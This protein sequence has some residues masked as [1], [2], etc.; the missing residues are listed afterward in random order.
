M[1]KVGTESKAYRIH[2]HV[3]LL[4]LL[5]KQTSLKLSIFLPFLTLDHQPDIGP[6]AQVRKY[7][8]CKL[9]L[10]SYPSVETYF[11]GTQ[12]TVHTE[13]VLT[14][15]LLLFEYP[16]HMFWLKRINKIYYKFLSGGLF[17]HTEGNATI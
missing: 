2:K 13:T 11:T 10:F 14:E 1:G 3:Q 6:L 16:Q 4:R 5:P 15:T 17:K 7:V 9:A 8:E 12:K